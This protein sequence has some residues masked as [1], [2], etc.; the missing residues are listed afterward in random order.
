MPTVL[1]VDDHES[2]RL[3]C[4]ANL[5][6]DGIRTVEAADGVEAVER[7][8]AEQP[9]AILLDVMLPRLSGW[10]VAETLRDDPQTSDIPIIFISAKSSL[11]DIAHGL[12]LG[13]LDYLTKPFDPE[14]LAPL[15]RSLLERI[16]HGEREFVRAERLDAVAARLTATKPS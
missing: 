6:S 14:A 1:V 4:R 10:E 7:A 11:W 5:E 2:I 16:A 8:R 13:G 15:I 3:L 12:E 9:D